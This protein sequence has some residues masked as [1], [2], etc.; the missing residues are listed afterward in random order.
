MHIAM[1]S[2]WWM[3]LLANTLKKIYIYKRLSVESLS[4]YHLAEGPS[5]MLGW[6]EHQ[7]PLVE[8]MAHYNKWEQYKVLVIIC[9]LFY[10][11]S[12]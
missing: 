10:L 2:F 3:Y 9:H 1:G 11:S 12:K 5:D 8:N 6:W 4:A 7:G